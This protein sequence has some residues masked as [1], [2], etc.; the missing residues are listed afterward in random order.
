[1]K[2]TKQKPI[3]SEKLYRKLVFSSFTLAIIVTVTMFIDTIITSSAQFNVLP[4]YDF[5]K[6]P[7]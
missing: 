6:I 2:N 1:M 3:N 5:E 4:D 7:E